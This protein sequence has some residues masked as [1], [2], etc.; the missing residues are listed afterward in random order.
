MIESLE[1]SEE[2][3]LGMLPHETF[4]YAFQRAR[5]R[6]GGTAVHMRKGLCVDRWVITCMCRYDCA[7]RKVARRCCME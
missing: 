7:S 2:V 6:R 1:L 4:L 3:R 5:V